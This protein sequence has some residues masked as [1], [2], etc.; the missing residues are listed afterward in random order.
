[1]SRIVQAERVPILR[2][3]KCR[4]KDTESSDSLYCL[5]VCVDD[6]TACITFDESRLPYFPVVF[7]MSFDSFRTYMSC[8][9][10]WQSFGIAE[11]SWRRPDLNDQPST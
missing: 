8:R 5:V 7:D 1:M 2:T 10:I 6:A 4:S 3:A 11:V 9:V